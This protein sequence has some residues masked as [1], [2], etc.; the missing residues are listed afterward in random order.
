MIKKK[1]PLHKDALD[2]VLSPV[3]SERENRT[4]KPYVKSLA[5]GIHILEGSLPVLVVE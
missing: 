1:S 3:G 2:L 4:K 5:V